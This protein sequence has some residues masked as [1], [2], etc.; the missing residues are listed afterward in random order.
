MED[1]FQI[2]F[3][4]IFI[5]SSIISS[6]NKKKK[7]QA[8]AAEVKN[9]GL[10]KEQFPSQ[11]E[12]KPANKILEELLGFKIEIPEPP[13]K[14]APISYSEEEESWDPAKEFETQVED[15]VSDYQKLNA[16]KKDQASQDR[17]KYQAFKKDAVNNKY[18]PKKV[19]KEKILSSKSNLKDYI[20]IQELLNKPKSL[21]R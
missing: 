14:E 1:Y 4:A 21:R 5:I 2:I 20:V 15:G 3:I 6:L 9:T 13:Q 7:Q 10:P 16:Q 8:K 19:S 18:I 11:R 17:T 12:Q